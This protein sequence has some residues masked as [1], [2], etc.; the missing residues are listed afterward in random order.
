MSEK[1]QARMS[2]TLATGFRRHVAL[3]G[4]RQTL[5]TPPHTWTFINT[6]SPFSGSI[7]GPP[8]ASHSWFLVLSARWSALI[9]PLLHLISSVTHWSSSAAHMRGRTGDRV[10]EHGREEWIFLVVWEFWFF[11]YFSSKPPLLPFPCYCSRLCCNNSIISLHFS[12]LVGARWG[13]ASPL[14]SVSLFGL[15]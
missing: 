8:P 9:L 1:H 13:P 3:T 10:K 12:G 4:I 5:T 11:L 15:S 14:L 7:K 6:V 2:S